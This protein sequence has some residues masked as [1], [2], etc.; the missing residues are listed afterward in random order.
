PSGSAFFMQ[1]LLLTEHPMKEVVILGV[2]ADG[3]RTSFLSALQKTFQPDVT[4]LAA[5]RPEELTDAA[6]FAAEYKPIGE[7][8]TVYVCENFTCQEPTTDIA[9]A[10][11][12]IAEN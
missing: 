3:T 10:L 6:P 12:K 9:E 1:S 2:A 11:E 7:D 4:V 5:E 8:T